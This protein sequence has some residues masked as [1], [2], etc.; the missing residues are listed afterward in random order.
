MKEAAIAVSFQS[1]A[2][3]HCFV[4]LISTAL[5]LGNEFSIGFLIHPSLSRN[6]HVQFLPAIQIFANL[7]GRIMPFW[8]AATLLLHIA[9]LWMTWRWPAKHTILLALAAALWFIII[10]FRTSKKPNLRLRNAQGAE[11]TRSS[12]LQNRLDEGQDRISQGFS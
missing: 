11:L 6:N 12:P 7:F 10:V 9:L 4:L 2:A 3:A 8:M 1:M 5:L